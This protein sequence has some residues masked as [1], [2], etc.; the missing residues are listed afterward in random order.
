MRIPKIISSMSDEEKTP[1]VVRLLEFIQRQSEKINSL[2][3]EIKILKGLKKRPKIKPSKLEKKS[4]KE[5]KSGKSSGPKTGSRKRKKTASLNIHE[6]N[7]VEPENV[8]DGSHFKGYNDFVVQDLAFEAFNVRY[9]LA[10]YET[11]DGKSVVGR[12]P[13]EVDRR[14]FGVKLRGFIL[15]Q[16]YHVHATQPAIREQLREIGCDVS[17][18][19]ISRILL[20]GKDAFHAEKEE[21]LRVGRRGFPVSER[22]R[23]RGAA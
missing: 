16:Y 6:D 8:P 18:G 9:R 1:T 10:R 2:E 14:H 23:H 17:P 7:V 12:L 22:G 3:D 5:K 21:I 4:E 11:P 13:S 20:E 15:Y 19:E